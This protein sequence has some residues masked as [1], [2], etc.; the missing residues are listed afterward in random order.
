LLKERHYI[1]RTK[2]AP[3]PLQVT[4]LV[5]GFLGDYRGELEPCPSPMTDLFGFGIIPKPSGKDTEA[6]GRVGNKQEKFPK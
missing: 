5:Y 6:R 4:G 1:T 3:G 2:K